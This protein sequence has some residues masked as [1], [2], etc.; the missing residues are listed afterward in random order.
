MVSDRQAPSGRS[1]RVLWAILPIGIVLSVTWVLRLVV[2]IALGDTQR[3]LS[4][5]SAVLGL[6]TSLT[7]IVSGLHYRRALRRQ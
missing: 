6:F 3:G 5:A 1:Q 7:L 4:I 2:E